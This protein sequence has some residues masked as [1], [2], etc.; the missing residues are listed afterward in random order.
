MK[1]TITYLVSLAA[2]GLLV[3]GCGGDQLGGVKTESSDI[4]K[5]AMT[6]PPACG[7]GI[8]KH[9]GSLGMAQQTAVARG[10]DML[11]RQ[12]QTKIEGMIKDYQESGETKEK[13]FTEELTTRVS[14]QIVDTTLV[15]TATKLAHLSSTG[16]QQYYALVCLQPEAFAGALDRMNDLSSRH[17]K[18]LKARAKMEF[19]DLDSQLE[20]L[21]QQ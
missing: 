5:W 3:T 1:T 15:G 4:P 18:A 21:R 12:L 16:P 9:R 19:K 10:R 17:R 7:V 14:R 11:A 8:A 6:P 20:K 2:I 13:D